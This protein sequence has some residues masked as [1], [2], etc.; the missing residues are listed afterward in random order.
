MEADRKADM[1]SAVILPRFPLKPWFAKT[2]REKK[3]SEEGYSSIGESLSGDKP[4]PIKPSIDLELWENERFR[5]IIL[6]LFINFDLIG[7]H[8]LRSFSS[9]YILSS[10]S[11]RLRSYL[12]ISYL[13]LFFTPSCPS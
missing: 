11:H 2:R 9:F 4:G 12:F 8:R 6:F 3:E 10:P 5:S 1:E 13:V 7:F